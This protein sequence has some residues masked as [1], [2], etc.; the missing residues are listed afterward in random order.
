VAEDQSLFRRCLGNPVC[1]FCLR[2]A[3]GAPS[4]GEKQWSVSEEAH[5]LR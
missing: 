4:L 5:K 1:C 3:V 2:E